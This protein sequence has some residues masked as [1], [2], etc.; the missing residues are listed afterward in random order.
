MP[1][2]SDKDACMAFGKGYMKDSEYCISCTKKSPT[3]SKK[4][5]KQTNELVKSTSSTDEEIEKFLKEL[6]KK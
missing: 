2:K 3:R 5:K 1:K 4:C 6:K